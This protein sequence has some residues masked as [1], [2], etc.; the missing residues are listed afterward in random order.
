MTLPLQSAPGNPSKA[1]ELDFKMLNNFKTMNV[2]GEEHDVQ[3]HM[4][5][6]PVPTCKTSIVVT[7]TIFTVF[8]VDTKE[9]TKR[10]L[11]RRPPPLYIGLE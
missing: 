7:A 4:F 5:R 10:W 8:K 1:S 9:T 6:P 3:S 2:Y 11:G